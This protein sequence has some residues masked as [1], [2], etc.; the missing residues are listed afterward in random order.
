MVEANLLCVTD[1]EEPL[2]L[3]WAS[4]IDWDDEADLVVVGFGGAGASAALE[5][6]EQ[7]AQVLVID[8]F[9]GGGATAYSGGIFYAGNTRIQREAGVED[10]AEEMFKYL[11]AENSPVKDETLQRFCQGSPD[12]FEWVARHVPYSSSFFSGKATFPPDGKFLYYSGNEKTPV[13]AAQAKPAARGHRAVGSGFTGHVF[14]AGLR[15]AALDAGARLI[16]HAPARR[17]VIDASGTVVGI[18]VDQMPEAAITDHQKLYKQV[19]PLVPLSG[20]RAEKAIIACRDFEINKA[21]RRRIR[22]R[23]GVVLSTGGFAYN[24]RFLQLYRPELAMAHAEIVRLGSMGCD[25]SGIAMGQSAGGVTGLMKNA[26]VGKNISPPEEYLHGI[27][28]NRQGERFV[29]EDAY[30]GVVGDAISQQS[31]EGAAWLVMSSAI[32]WKAFWASLTMGRGRF[33][34]YGLPALMNI[35]FGKPRR[36]RTLAALAKKCGINAEGLEASVLAY[37][38]AATA[39]TADVFGKLPANIVPIGKG[40]YWALNMGTRNGFGMTM[41]FT[42]GGLQ[43]DE[44]TGGVLRNDGSTVPGLYAAGRTAIGVCSGGYQSGMSLADLVFSGRRAAVNASRRLK[45][46]DVAT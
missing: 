21:V 18:E 19:N 25:G 34:Y 11:R 42:L 26:Y 1:V 12:D 36:G 31:G 9:D 33:F 46:T 8:R 38:K 6:R 39:G 7:G 32:Y 17:L 44:A 30:I 14:Y 27:L 4:D 29:H 40:P 20:K 2:R 15:K 22:A 45:Q 5:G 3:A 24:I 28:V 13:Y 37:D 41:A 35:L 10:S 16:A 43:V 23:A